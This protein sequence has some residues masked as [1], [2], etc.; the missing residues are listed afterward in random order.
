[1]NFFFFFNDNSSESKCEGTVI[2]LLVLL[3]FVYQG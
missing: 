1:M 3:H 2:E